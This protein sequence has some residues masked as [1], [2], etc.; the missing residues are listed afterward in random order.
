VRVHE[1]SKYDFVLLELLALVASRNTT[2]TTKGLHINSMPL[3]IS[4]S[5]ESSV[6]TMELAV[7]IVYLNTPKG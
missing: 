2:G 4:M 3:I 7:L 1:S 5:N 6:E